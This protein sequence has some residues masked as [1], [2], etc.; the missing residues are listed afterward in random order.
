MSQRPVAFGKYLLLD[1]IASGGMAE[2]W[3]AKITGSAGFE[4]LVVIKRILPHLS[5]DREF[6][7]M[8]KAEARITMNLTH[9]NIAQMYDM[10]QISN[11]HFIVLEYIP[12]KNLKEII[13][14]CQEKTLYL[15]IEQAVFVASEVCKGLEFAHNKR[16]SS[17]M[18]IIHRDISP[19]NIMVSYEGEVKI[20]DFGIAKAKG[21]ANKTQAGVLKGKFGYMSPEQATGA[22]LDGRSDVFSLGIVLW[23]MLTGRRL[24][25]G[26]SDFETLERVKSLEVPPPSMYNPGVHRDLN[27]ITLK[28]LDRDDHRRYPSAGAMQIDLQ[29]FLSVHYADYTPFKLASFMKLL[30]EREIRALELE[31]Q[32]FL[33]TGGAG[34]DS[35]VENSPTMRVHIPKGGNPA[36]TM[37]APK[38]APLEDDDLAIEKLLRDEEPPARDD[39]DEFF[40]DED[41]PH[42]SVVKNVPAGDKFAVIK[43]KAKA[44][45][46]DPKK[47]RITI[48]IAFFTVVAMTI[49]T[50]DSI[51]ETNNKLQWVEQFKDVPAK[52]KA[53]IGFVTVESEPAGAKVFFDASGANQE[54]A[55]YTPLP[56]FKLSTKS[57]LLRLE[58]EH[59]EPI[60]VE[61]KVEPNTLDNPKLLQY[62]LKRKISYGSLNV[63]SDPTD[64][65]IYVD[66]ALS[67]FKTPHEFPE[68][69][70]EKRHTIRV[71][72]EGYKEVEKSVFINPNVQ[73]QINVHLYPR[74]GRIKVRSVPKSANVYLDG[75]S[76]GKTPLDL[77]DIYPGREYRIKLELDGYVAKEQV[78]TLNDPDTPEDV[79]MIL[80]KKP[81]SY[82]YLELQAKPWA[83]VYIND[84]YVDDTPSKTQLQGEKSY[85]VKLVHPKFPPVSFT[86]SVPSNDTVKKI[87]DMKNGGEQE[88]GGSPKE[89]GGDEGGGEEEF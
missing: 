71:A 33:G 58:K 12:G 42:P 60:E 20:V 76:M 24:F 1:K 62:T 77:Y 84:K 46:A 14:R 61:I 74:V 26:D 39:I 28:A 23:E 37:M 35:D 16:I 32:V 21:M 59:Y 6:A 22:E 89:K 78:V 67:E 65:D 52:Q 54:P 85:K 63:T 87:I 45:W 66:G 81:P 69:E 17:D 5:E 34:D 51:R 79:E 36:H 50:F 8:F 88:G 83:R 13:K 49:Q 9:Q 29:R 7:E 70:A 68:I 31:N 38:H 27:A 41:E 19:Q 64:A 2:I 56:L 43:A 30:F 57:H 55:G 47:R 25:L 18:T 86:V 15:S 53:N 11:T 4:K 80:K 10:G 44:L 72:K 73:E 48:I 82:G 40:A 3:K 75:D